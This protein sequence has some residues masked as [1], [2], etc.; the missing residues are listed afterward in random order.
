MTTTT[1]PEA[2]TP[3][4]RA[5]KPRSLRRRVLSR[6]SIQS[7]LLVMLLVTSILSAAVVGA[8]GYQS[9]WSSLR[10]SVFDRLTEIRAAQARQ[11]ESQFTDMK[12]S[13]VIYTR[14]STAAE[15]VE[16]FTSGFDQLAGATINPN[17]QR[18]IVDY[19]KKQFEKTEEAQTG[20]QIDVNGL[21]PTSN[22]QKYLQAYY[23]TPFTDWEKAISFD[24][25]HD[26][27]A[28]SARAADHAELG[29]RGCTSV[30]PPWRMDSSATSGGVP[31]RKPL[32]LQDIGR[33]IEERRTS[34]RRALAAA[35]D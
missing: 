12:N 1:E 4:E 20:D 11:L 34:L 18:S 25:A 7:K 15:A 5:P 21:L 14:G 24:D 35:G 32:L 9:G 13:L 22:A 16:A 6:I 28:W 17:K 26:G 27:S 29:A 3:T 19:Y 30:V 31:A 23:T 33:A 8:I 10:A 2:S